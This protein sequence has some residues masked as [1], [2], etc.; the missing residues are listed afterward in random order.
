M[1]L[2]RPANQVI[3]HHLDVYGGLLANNGEDDVSKIVDAQNR[4]LRSIVYCPQ[5]TKGGGLVRP[6][7]HEGDR[8]GV[9]EFPV[10]HTIVMHLCMDSRL[11]HG[12]WSH[13]IYGW[14]TPNLKRLVFRLDSEDKLPASFTIFKAM[15][16]LHRHL[17]AI[18][19]IVYDLKQEYTRLDLVAPFK[20]ISVADCLTT[21][22]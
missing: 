19:F 2:Y 6:K 22:E 9:V 15:F 8:D 12:F 3:I 20:I 13:V 7:Y 16:D 21:P 17:Q 14:N 10:L 5:Q 11:P 4:H 18:E 1:T